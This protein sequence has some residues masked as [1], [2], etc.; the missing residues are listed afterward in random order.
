M[1]YFLP[2][3]ETRFYASVALHARSLYPVVRDRNDQIH[4]GRNLRAAPEPFLKAV[5]PFRGGLVIGCE[6][7]GVERSGTGRE[8]AHRRIR[9]RSSRKPSG[10]ESD[11]AG[12]S[13][14]TW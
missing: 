7:A 1:C 2:P 5:Q 12:N 9:P 4:F 8:L 13:P 10:S 11:R 14:G 6:C 3:P